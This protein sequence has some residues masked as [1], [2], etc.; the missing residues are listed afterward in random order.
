MDYT[1]GESYTLPSKG[2]VYSET[3]NPQIKIRSMT[4]QEE[5]KRLGHSDAPYKLLSEIIDDCLVENPGISAYDLCIGDYQYL[6]HRL[7]AVTYGADYNIQL[8]CPICGAIHK[9]VLNLDELEVIEYSDDMRKYL[10]ITLPKS[11]KRVELKLQTPRMLDEITQKSDKIKKQS[12][13]M[14]GEPAF[15]FTLESLIYKVDGQVLNPIKL[16][17]FVRSL[18]MADAN[19]I[20]RSV[21]KVNIGVKQNLTHKCKDCKTEF[22]Y[23]FPITGEFFGPSID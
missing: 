3:V 21:E 14:E 11:K 9:E 16:T 7:R 5:M 15:L 17:Q 2:Q 6:L 12:P 1:I 22:K 20:L 13:D 18:E 10:D 19:Y 8:I 23:T 4:T